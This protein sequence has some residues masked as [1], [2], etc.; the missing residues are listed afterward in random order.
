MRRPLIVVGPPASLK[1]KVAQVLSARSGRRLATADATTLLAE[2]S[3]HDAPV[4]EVSSEAWLD[5]ALRVAAMDRCVVVAVVCV[6]SHAAQ[7]VA[8]ASLEAKL[9]RAAAGAFEEAHCVVYVEDG[10]VE[11]AATEVLQVWERDPIGVAAGERSYRVEVG[12]G[13]VDSR[14]SG[15]LVGSATNLLVTDSTVERLYGARF[16]AALLASGSRL[17]KVVFEAGEQQKH[18]QTLTK[19]YEAAQLGG[20]DRSSKVVAIGGGVVTD[21]AG[22][23]AATW[24][25]GLRWFGISTTLLGMVDASV[26]GKTAVD[27]GEGKNAV[28]AFWQPSGVVCD[29]E[30]LVTEGERNFRGALA[31]VVKTALIGDRELFELLESEAPAIARRDSAL[32]A[33]VVRCC[34]RVKARIVGEDETEKGLRATLN[35]GHTV[36]HALEAVGGY[37]RLSH[38]EAVSLGLVAALRIGVRLGFTPSGIAERIVRLQEALELPVVLDSGDLRAA[39]ELLCHDKKKTGKSIRFIVVEDVGCVTHRTLLVEELRAMLAAIAG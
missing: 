6:G 10:T 16:E 22:F 8:P 4:I 37:G 23:A 13:I 7:P 1:G 39:G 11:E 36:G 26:G 32:M 29:T 14:L 15:L 38:G 33:E 31:E 34:V 17:V 18:L 19:I 25:R 12:R 21:V 9:W 5:R 2:W 30:L 20:I 27:F 3:G 35:L 24:M 28:G